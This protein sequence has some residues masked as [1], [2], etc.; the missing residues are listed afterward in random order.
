MQTIKQIALA[1]VFGLLTFTSVFALNNETHNFSLNNSKAKKLFSPS[2]TF[3]AI[4]IDYDVTEGK[5]DGMRIHV[6]FTVYGMKNLDSYLAI[7]FLDENGD[8][9]RDNNGRY[10]SSDGEVAVYYALKPGY[11]TT[12][13]DDLSVFMPY[14]ELDLDD[15][16]W[17]LRIDADVIYKRGGLIQHLTFKDINYKQGE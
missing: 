4:W 2:A 16:N 3:K 1:A 14:D 7:Y 10:N 12:D 5:R 11:A 9:L 15:G 8:K 17:D 6:K 13:Y